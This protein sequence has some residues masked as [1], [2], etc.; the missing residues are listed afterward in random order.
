MNRISWSYNQWILAFVITVISSLLFLSSSGFANDNDDSGIIFPER[1]N[2]RLSD[3]DA[4]DKDAWG[5]GG[6]GGLVPGG[7]PNKG[8]PGTGGPSN[9][10]PG[11][12]DPDIGGPGTGGPGT[13][14]PNNG[15]PGGG[16]DSDDRNW[17][18]KFWDDTKEFYNDAKG[19][20][21][22]AWEESVVPWWEENGAPVVEGAKNILNDIQ[23]GA[24]IAFQLTWDTL[25]Q[26]KIDN[27]V[28]VFNNLTDSNWWSELGNS[29][30]SWID[31]HFYIFEI[32]ALT[33]VFLAAAVVFVMVVAPV[34]LAGALV[35]GAF[36]AL[37][38]TSAIIYGIR[39]IGTGDFNIFSAIAWTVTPL[40]GFAGIKVFAANV[41]RMG[42]VGQAKF[43]GASF[44]VPFVIDFAFN[45]LTNPGMGLGE[46]FFSATIS[47]IAGVFT[48]GMG[49]AILGASSKAARFGTAVLGGTL[50]GL[51][52]FIAKDFSGNAGF[53]D[54]TL[55][56]F[57]TFTGGY[58]IARHVSPEKQE[59]AFSFLW[60]GV[61][62]G[63]TAFADWIKDL[64][65]GEKTLPDANTEKS[66]VEVNPE[67]KWEGKYY[68]P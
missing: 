66:N 49:A 17:L 14:G 59:G 43:F 62:N 47:G 68:G 1:E 15:D 42:L 30:L 29:I 23:N 7:D 4:E 25:V 12:G 45:L 33:L 19:Y 64:F 11:T 40:L 51:T 26:P 36:V 20:L 6:G 10:D 34:T 5:P 48:A 21:E 13:G 46:R 28:E 54:F 22:T 55:G 44:G 56:F 65:T 39:T 18:S 16:A 41:V 61:Q 52:H 50:G 2:S 27:L 37:S 57:L 3:T 8:G 63:V 24:E 67:T 9:G 31:E 60:E 38:L 58:L 53:S 35:A 32:A